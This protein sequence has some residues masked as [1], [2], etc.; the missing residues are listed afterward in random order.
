MNSLQYGCRSVQT[1]RRPTGSGSSSCQI[2]S[3]AGIGCWLLVFSLCQ[4]EPSDA[5]LKS[6]LRVLKGENGLS[7][8]KSLRVLSAL[9]R[10]QGRLLNFA[11][12]CVG[13]ASTSTVRARPAECE[14]GVVTDPDGIWMR[15]YVVSMLVKRKVIARAA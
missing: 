8:S 12:G 1:P 2:V 15:Y 13:Q 5:P 6:E 11:Q 9:V 7:A 3:S 4:K 14:R 10:D